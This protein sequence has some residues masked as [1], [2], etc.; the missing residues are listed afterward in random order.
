M[1]GVNEIGNSLCVLIENFYPYFYIRYPSR[2]S[3]SNLGDL[4][5]HFN[6]LIASKKD[7]ND[8]VKKLELVKKIDLKFYHESEECFLK[9]TFKNT[10]YVSC[11]REMLESSTENELTKF[12]NVFFETKTYESKLS[13]PLRYMIDNGIVGMSWITIPA[14]KY[15]L[16][17][18][19]NKISNCQIELVVNY[20]DIEAHPP[21]N[22]YS[23]IAP[24]RILSFDIECAAK[25]GH[26]PKADND[27]IIQIAN[28]CV[29]FGKNNNE[30]IVKNLFSFK[31]CEEIPGADV[32][33]FDTEVDMLRAWR[34][35][36]VDLD[37]DII[38]GYNINNFD[39][40]Y[41][42]DRAENLKIR[43][44]GKISRMK[45]TITKAKH[46]GAN[47]AKAFNNRDLININMDGRSIIDMYLLIVKD[48]RLRS[49]TLNNVAFHFL[50]EQKED[51][52]HTMI[53]ELWNTNEIT[54]RRL[55]QY[56]LKDAY[57]PWKLCE[58]LMTIYNYAEMCRVTCTPL[59]FIL[60]RGQQIKVSSQLHRKALL[61][62]YI[63]PNERIKFNNNDDDGI[64]FEGASVLDPIPKFYDV[65]IVTLDFASLYPS[66]MIAHNLC[67][68]TLVKDEDVNKYDEKDLFHSPIGK[69]FI[70]AH[71]RKGI[72]PIILEDLISARKKA[73]KDLKEETDEAIRAVLDGRQLALK[74]SANSVYGFTGAQVGQLPCLEISATVTSVGRSMIERTRDFVESRFNIKNGFQYDSQVVY[75][76]TDSVMIK[77][78]IKTLEEAMV[79]GK[80]ASELIS[81]QFQKPIKLE[82]E[83][84]YLP[85]LL[86]KKKRY[87]GVIWTKVDKYDKIDTKGLESVRRD[88]CELVKEVLDKVMN[89]LL[90]DIE[91][92]RDRSLEYC[93][94]IISDLLAN[95]IDLSKLIITKSISKKSDEDGDDKEN[96]NK[97]KNY[98]AKQAH[99]ELAEKMKKRDEGTAPTVGDRVQYI[100][101]SG[102]K[103]SKNYNNS[104]DPRYV[105]EKDIPIDFRYYIDNQLKK[106]LLRL[107]EYVI[108]NVEQ[109]LF[110]KY[111][112]IK[113]IPFYNIYF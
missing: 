14:N 68:T 64:G 63:I 74:I 56:C 99:V 50:K 73:K 94:G 12:N 47:S 43:D 22:E 60:T 102:A 19:D 28:Y 96:T 5:K 98:V 4:L 27:P 29:E 93:K 23:R 25:G 105:L 24:I 66:I 41:L 100:M 57:L 52:H 109:K 31:H 30:A 77:F 111:L 80:Q 49:N 76:D 82:F 7:V 9:I 13:F 83:K 78:G 8:G 36:I 88:N 55:G 84:V 18:E 2:L 97:G 112:L 15:E 33:S 69:T 39:F 72:L 3:E 1:Y 61:Q 87:A 89:M 70:K 51:V 71:K 26:F 6:T 113:I 90:L 37:P 48:H 104:E 62:N 79:L 108:P 11:L 40:T 110:S 44:F 45:K 101:I 107:F 10:K 54:R 34:Q 16:K 91:H 21:E 17:Q 46:A 35:F 92:G 53:Y 58:K 32:H 59:S 103:G 81:E 106:P 65:P 85:Y 75:G 38:T 86:M 95:R 42:F 67:Y 20:K